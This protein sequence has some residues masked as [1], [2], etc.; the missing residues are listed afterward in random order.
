MSQATTI[1]SKSRRPL[2]ISLAIVAVLAITLISASGVYTD[3]LWFSQLGYVSVFTTQI[4]AQVTVFAVS[5]IFAGLVIW[6]NIFVAWKFRPIYVTNNDFFGRD[7][8]E[9]R[10]VLDRL[11]RRLL[12]VVPLVI[13]IFL[14]MSQ[15]S[16]WATVYTFINHSYTGVLDP[17]FKLDIGFYLFDLPFYLMLVGYLLGVILLSLIPT[18]IFHLVYGG[19][20]FNGRNSQL[21]KVARIQVNP[22][23]IDYGALGLQPLAWPV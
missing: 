9:Y 19:I 17:Q 5:A 21:S 10:T 22:S 18:I 6:V 15:S 2:L 13:A 16:D 11:R 14:A 4:F 20:K 1:S 8:G 7:L 3:V 12:I 23:R